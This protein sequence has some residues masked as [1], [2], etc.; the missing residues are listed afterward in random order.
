MFRDFGFSICP[1]VQWKACMG[2]NV[3]A[4]NGPPL[5]CN[6]LNKEITS[7]NPLPVR[8][9]GKLYFPPWESNI[10]LSVKPS[11]HKGL[12]LLALVLGMLLPNAW[13]LLGIHPQLQYHSLKEI[14]SVS[15]QRPMIFAAVL[16]Q[17]PTKTKAGERVRRR[18]RET[19]KIFNNSLLEELWYSHAIQYYTMTTI[20]FWENINIHKEP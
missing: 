4:Q 19:P 15:F 2:D 7:F 6:C 18:E 1:I 16:F 5:N 17:Q 14:L 10:V 9:R 8:M 12:Y 20:I 13:F 11:F 3:A